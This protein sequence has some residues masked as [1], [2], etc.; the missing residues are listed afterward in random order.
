MNRGIGFV[1]FCSVFLVSNPTLS[2]AKCITLSI[3]GCFSKTAS[4]DP[5]F[6]TSTL[7]NSGLF[8]QMSS[9]R[10]IVSSEELY[11]LSAIT[12]LYPSSRSARAVNDPI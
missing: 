5:S 2:A 6:V 12:T 4:N 1:C 10:L 8:P 7:K 11:K 3:S 9:I